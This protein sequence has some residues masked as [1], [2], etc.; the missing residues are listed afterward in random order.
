MFLKYGGKSETGGKM[1]H[2]LRGGW[3]PLAVG[4]SRPIVDLRYSVTCHT[5]YFMHH[6]A[7]S[8]A[9]DLCTIV[10]KHLSP[11]QCV[12]LGMKHKQAP[13]PQSISSPVSEMP[14]VHFI[15]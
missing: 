14:P 2:G 10:D 3:T 12:C 5:T 1:H 9:I 6:L 13:P 8:A 11:L 7:L 4:N 15:C